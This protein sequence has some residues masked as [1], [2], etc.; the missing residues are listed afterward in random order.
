MV[1]P[2]KKGEEGSG[3]GVGKDRERVSKKLRRENIRS[4]AGTLAS[5]SQC[6]ETICR[7]KMMGI[8]KEGGCLKL[9]KRGGK[10]KGELV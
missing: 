3:T 8:S 5:I 6:L 10:R 2:D 9:K 1:P 4:D 7:R